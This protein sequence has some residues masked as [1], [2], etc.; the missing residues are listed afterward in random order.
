MFVEESFETFEWLDEVFKLLTAK[1]ENE[2]LLTAKKEN[3]SYDFDEIEREESMVSSEEFMDTPE[4]YAEELQY[5]RTTHT[6]KEGARENK[7][8]ASTYGNWSTHMFMFD[9]LSEM[10]RKGVTIRRLPPQPGRKWSTRF[11]FIDIDNDAEKGHD[12]PNITKDELEQVLPTLGYEAYSLS[13]STSRNP[14]KWHIITFLTTPVRTSDE[15]D[16]AREDADG[17]L[18]KAIAELRGIKSLPKLVDPTVKWQSSFYGP[19]QEEEREVVFEDL[20]PSN[21]YITYAK[22]MP[23]LERKLEAPTPRKPR[24]S[25][26]AYFK[27]T[28]I[29]LTPPKFCVWLRKTGLATVERIDDLEY[30]F[31]LGGGILPYLRPGKRKGVD[32]IEEGKRYNTISIFMLKLYAQARS[33]NL[34]LEEHGFGDRKFT[35]DNIVW[36]FEDYLQ[37]AVEKIEG[38]DMEKH[39]KELR[40]LIS[41]NADKSDREYLESVKEFASGRTRF[42]TRCYTSETAAKIC[43]EFLDCDGTVKFD[44][45]EYRE[46]YLRDQR[47]SLPTLRKVASKRGL[48]ISC[49]N[50]GGARKG[51]GPKP[52]I[53]WETLKSKGDVLNG[54]FYYTGEL[55]S[56]EKKFIQRE[57][58]SVKKK[59]DNSK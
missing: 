11:L 19:Y 22:N 30:D 3:E 36:S 38:Y 42:K 7:A 28:R 43:D 8:F 45:V 25:V 4:G 46:S 54:V 1:K 12:A 53:T 32:Q 58:L 40:S 5:V 17:R 57:G 10:H 51:T 2:S 13:E 34:Y 39:V 33:Y 18:R 24:T 48:K 26:E 35:D 31:K 29:P 59:K 50:R 44:S 9:E 52:S 55:S 47:V 20:D 41:S 15:Y 49:G 23:H 6:S 21:G 37:R 56:A 27:D 16:M 14:Y